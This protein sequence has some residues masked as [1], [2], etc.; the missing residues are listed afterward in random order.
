M[1]YDI[2]L[3]DEHF[4][5]TYNVSNMFYKHNEKGIRELYGKNGKEGVIFLLDLINFF[6]YNYKDLKKLEP[7]NGWGTYKDTLC[8]LINMLE[9]SYKYPNE[10]WEGD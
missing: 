10:I 3:K 9:A 5:I 7:D 4:N 8:I 6:V 1:S 2:H